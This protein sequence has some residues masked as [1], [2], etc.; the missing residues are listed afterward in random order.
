MPDVDP[1]M[2]ASF[3]RNEL[4]WVRN[5]AEASLIA[6]GSWSEAER[7]IYVRVVRMMQ[8]MKGGPDA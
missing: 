8:M 1:T 3:S 6:R 5:W 4:G 2:S 7:T